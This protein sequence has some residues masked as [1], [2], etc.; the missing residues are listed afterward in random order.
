MRTRVNQ[1]ENGK[2][3]RGSAL[4]E[5]T[6]TLMLFLV[7]V[8]SLFDFGFSLFLH[9][10]L[11]HQARSGA[12]YGATCL[13]GPAVCTTSDIKNVVLYNQK[14]GSG[15]GVMGLAPSAVQVTRAG[16]AGLPD[17]R[18]VVAITGYSFTTVTPGWSGS[19]T[20]KPIIVT[21]PVKN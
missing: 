21:I 19:H 10:T 1:A 13:A 15:N 3:E 11:V 8:F 6:L 20:G 12:R 17:D 7:L 18:I 4:V 16:T 14:S 5:A 2:R 9:Q